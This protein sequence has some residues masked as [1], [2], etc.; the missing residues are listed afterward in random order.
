MKDGLTSPIIQ[1]YQKTLSENPNSRVFAPLAESYRRLS[2]HD[3]AF[4]LLKEGIKRNPDY[5]LGYLVLAS[6]YADKDEHQLVYT[7]LRPLV[8]NNR[9]NLRLQKLFAQSCLKLKHIDEALE[10]YKYLLFMNPRDTEIAEKVKELD[11][12]SPVQEV[13]QV[14]SVNVE[15]EIND[16]FDVE[17]LKVSPD[18][19]LDSW[20]QKDFSKDSIKTNETEDWEVQ[21]P[22]EIKIDDDDVV[23]HDAEEEEREFKVELSDDEPRDV[24]EQELEEGPVITHTLVDLYCAQGHF[25]KAIEILEKILALNPDD[26]LTQK[27]L[28]EVNEVYG[29]QVGQISLVKEPNEEEVEL[30]SSEVQVDVDEVDE[31][32]EKNMARETFSSDTEGR[33]NLMK[34]FD[35]KVA[36]HNELYPEQAESQDKEEELE[37]VDSGVEEA[38]KPSENIQ[39]SNAEISE[40]RDKLMAFLGAVK[41]RAKLAREHKL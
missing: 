12:I 41:I 37:L 39:H 5:V 23:L 20:V 6:C 3:R 15:D 26:K 8:H 22:Y 13:V 21:K 1:K 24:I 30:E 28:E 4:E 35:S 14:E 16:Q 38:I 29:S 7:T 19:D 2:L 36:E 10:T 18:D 11:N 32:M 34:Y 17:K 25:S 9:D 33:D 31:A 27:K 40:K